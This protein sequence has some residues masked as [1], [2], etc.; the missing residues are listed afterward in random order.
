M[1]EV[2]EDQLQPIGAGGEVEGR[3]DLAGAEVQMAVVG[4][5]GRSGGRGFR[6]DEQVVMAGVR[7]VFARGRHLHRSFADALS[8]FQDPATVPAMVAAIPRS[9]TQF[10][11]IATLKRTLG[12]ETPFGLMTALLSERTVTE[13]RMDRDRRSERLHQ[14]RRGWIIQVSA[15]LRQV[16][17]SV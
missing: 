3:F 2:S 14:V 1:Q 10:L 6:V 15:N 8:S 13:A 17:A 7:P 9:M 11:W 4:W 5:N 12:V 16:G